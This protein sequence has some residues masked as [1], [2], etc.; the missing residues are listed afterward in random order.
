MQ[1]AE[2]CHKNTCAKFYGDN[3]K[4]ITVVMVALLFVV[5]ASIVSKTLS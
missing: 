5:G 2:I 1:K 4:I 3:A